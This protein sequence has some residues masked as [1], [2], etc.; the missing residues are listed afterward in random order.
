ML[1]L[2]MEAASRIT[3]REPQLLRS[4]V[5]IYYASDQRLNISKAKKELDYAPRNPQEAIREALEYISSNYHQL[6]Y[7]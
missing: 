1:A 6:Q 7:N 5:D 4:Q 2:F 3:G